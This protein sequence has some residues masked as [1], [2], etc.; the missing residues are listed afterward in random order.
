MSA[1]VPQ[2]TNFTKLCIEPNNF[3]K[4]CTV[5]PSGR[6]PRNELSLEKKI[7]VILMFEK[8]KLSSRAI[9]KH[10]SL[11][12]YPC[13]K[14]QIQN[15]IKRKQEWIREFECNTPLARKRK[16]RKTCYEELN[17]LLFEWFKDYATTLLPITGPMLQEKAREIAALLGLD[18]FKASNGWLESFRKRNNILFGKIP[19]EPPFLTENSEIDWKLQL[20]KICANYSARDIFNMDEAGLLFK[21]STTSNQENNYCESEE[22]ITLLLCCNALGEKEMPMMI[23]KTM[24]PPSFGTLG[25]KDLPVEYHAQKN[26]LMTSDLFMCYLM[27]LN[28]K[29][30]QQRRK[31]L[32]IL[33][34]APCHPHLL[35]S[36]IKLLF[37][38]LNKTS[39]MQ[40]LNDGIIHA[41]KLRFR[42]RQLINIW[43]NLERD[44][45]LTGQ[46]LIETTD[47]LQVVYWLHKSWHDVS[48]N[49]IKK[50]F[51]KCGV[52]VHVDGDYDEDDDQ[53]SEEIDATC[54]HVLEIS[55]KDFVN[56]DSHL[57]TTTPESSSDRTEDMQEV[58]ETTENSN[59]ND[60]CIVEYDSDIVM[61]KE[62]GIK[63]WQEL[64][65]CIAEIRSFAVSN[66]Y[67]ALLE[68]CF[69]MEETVSNE[70]INQVQSK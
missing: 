7:E 59:D 29:M 46:E 67:S 70:Y 45:G 65:N 35:L 48:P 25:G 52:S 43:Q 64:K 21:T 30:K 68:K 33:D 54:Q 23:G 12:G 57:E 47:M 37:L 38:P 53:F 10:L 41:T 4:L 51:K 19:E 6:A 44:Q 66:G 26:A 2:P 13:G 40:P 8:Q 27:N 50:C 31:I 14:T 62:S 28:N 55:M 69:D 58:V 11:H 16:T 63:N 17:S 20:P 60:D 42:K 9:A 32:M 39:I 1:Q 49:T 36:N 15:I 18:E 24:Q 3:S 34:D 56:I 61:P 22:Q 5:T